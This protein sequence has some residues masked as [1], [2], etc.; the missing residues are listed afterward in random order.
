MEY[1]EGNAD[2][3]ELLNKDEFNERAV[4]RCLLEFGLKEWEPGKTVADHLLQECIDEEMI[5]NSSLLNIVNTYKVWYEKDLEPTAEKLF[6][7]R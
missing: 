5:T 7:Q 4:V 2:A 1:S 6:I 3:L